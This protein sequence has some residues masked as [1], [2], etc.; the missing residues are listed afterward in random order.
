[1]WQVFCY[2]VRIELG[3]V[4]DGV[5]FSKN[6]QSRFSNNGGEENVGISDD[7]FDGHESPLSHPVR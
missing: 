5:E 4:N 6:S 1:M 2:L 3:D 7:A